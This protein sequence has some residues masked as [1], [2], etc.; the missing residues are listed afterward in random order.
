MTR[1]PRPSRLCRPVRLR[2]RTVLLSAFVPLLFAAR[3]SSQTI[4]DPSLTHTG[5]DGSG[6]W[7]LGTANWASAGADILW[8]NAFTNIATFGKGGV[9]GTVT[10][11]DGVQTNGLV[12]NATSSG[13]YLLTGGTLFFGGPTPTINTAIDASITASLNGGGLTLTKSGTGTLSLD[14]ATTGIPTIKVTGGTLKTSTGGAGSFGNSTTAI[15]VSNNAKIRTTGSITVANPITLNGG[16]GDAA[17]I[18]G[19]TLAGPVV[20]ASGDSAINASAQAF[21]SGTISGAGNL[22]KSGSQKLTVTGTNTYSGTTTIS[23]GAI[24]VGI[25]GTTGTLGSG[26]VTNNGSLIYNRSD[27]FTVAN[28]ISGVGSL[29]KTGDGTMILSGINVYTG[30]TTITQGTLEVN[31]TI[32]G[33]SAS[34]VI[35]GGGAEL[36]GTGTITGASAGGV[37]LLGGAVLSPGAADSMGTLSLTSLSWTSNNTSAGMAFNLSNVDS[38]SDLLSLSGS[39][40]RSSNTAGAF[41]FDFQNS[42]LLGN[43]YTLMTFGSTGSTSV[44]NLMATNLPE[45]LTGTFQMTST[46][47]KL[48][49]VP[50]PSIALAGG[51]GMLLLLSRAR[52]RPPLG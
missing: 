10:I 46:N 16:T 29:T 19:A 40:T 28:T 11:A 24:Q 23:N 52:R 49:V 12:F 6:T 48:V 27:T 20:L 50:E 32:A 14:G 36:A 37:T 31:G 9:A 39:F 51:V 45:G 41:I 30:N 38:S 22:I 18:G 5:S 7:D 26:A 43:T 35:V 4:W 8:P 44:A 33:G 2:Y 13:N 34:Q 17:T 25:S 42:G 3:A 15:V 1:N 47:L 21:I